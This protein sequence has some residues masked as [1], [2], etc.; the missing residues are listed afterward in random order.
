MPAQPATH[1]SKKP[2]TAF[3]VELALEFAR[4]TEEAA[5]ASAKTM[6]MGDAKLADQAATEA[7]RRAMHSVPM[8]GRIVIG[9]GERDQA[10][11]L[12]IGEEVGFGYR[13]AAA[14]E[15]QEVDIAVD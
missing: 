8:R 1:S 14:T 11:M 5:I 6:G 2:H 13:S 12:F 15:Y 4:V 10:P 9:E 3:E 7:M